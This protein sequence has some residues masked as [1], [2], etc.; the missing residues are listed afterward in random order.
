MRYG[1]TLEQLHTVRVAEGWHFRYGGATR[2]GAG[3]PRY[4][5]GEVY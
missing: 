3:G 4:V 1:L 5:E 2:G